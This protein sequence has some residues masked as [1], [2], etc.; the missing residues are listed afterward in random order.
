MI[1]GCILALLHKMVSKADISMTVIQ[2]HR[3]SLNIVKFV[4]E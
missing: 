2:H 4:S 1:A 3:G